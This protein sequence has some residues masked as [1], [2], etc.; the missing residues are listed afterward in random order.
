MKSSL[1]ISNFLEEISSLFQSIVFLYFFALIAEEGFLF[2]PCYSLEFC[3]Q[4]VIS[5]LFSFALSFSFLSY[6]QGLVKYV[7]EDKNLQ[8]E[9][10]SH[11]F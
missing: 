5:F 1:G 9:H 4:L 10:V 8:I 11:L 3:I 6:L 2:S 7:S